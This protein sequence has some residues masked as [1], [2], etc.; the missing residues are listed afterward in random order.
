MKDARAIRATFS[1]WRTVKSRKAL[2]LVFEVPLEQQAE[3]LTMLGAPLPDEPKWCAIALLNSP[4]GAHSTK[5]DARLS[6]DTP[7][8]EPKQ[9]R[10]WNTL[11]PQERAGILCGDRGF[12]K[13]V[14]QQ[15]GWDCDE[16]DARD[17]LCTTLGIKSRAELATSEGAAQRFDAIDHRFRIESGREFEVR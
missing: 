5:E 14:S 6:G 1:D 9:R 10:P 11:S 12:Q 2:Q 15:A 13:W 7:A 3:V 17:W 4:A 8:G 16:Q